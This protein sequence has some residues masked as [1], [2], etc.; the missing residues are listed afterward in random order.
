MVL[1]DSPSLDFMSY[2][3]LLSN[4]SRRSFASFGIVSPS[5][6]LVEGSLSMIEFAVCYCIGISNSLVKLDI[7]VKFLALVSDEINSASVDECVD[8]FVAHL[9]PL[10]AC[11][12]RLADFQ[13]PISWYPY[14]PPSVIAISVTCN[15]RVSFFLYAGP[16]LILEERYR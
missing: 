1:L 12:L 9:S 11:H 2:A 6:Y 13:I 3:P 7:Q 8:F 15:S 16:S 10:L 4:N 5:W 14:T